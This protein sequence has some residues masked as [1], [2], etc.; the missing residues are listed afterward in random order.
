ML[1]I[2]QLSCYGFVKIHLIRLK[3]AQ[4]KIDPFIRF[5][6]SNIPTERIPT[7]EKVSA[8]ITYIE[9]TKIVLNKIS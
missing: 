8:C 3:P 4:I 7:P 9:T 6:N 2:K 1:K 5:L